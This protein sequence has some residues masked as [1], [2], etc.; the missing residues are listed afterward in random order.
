MNT[1][2]LVTG[3]ACSAFG[4]FA[5]FNKEFMWTLTEWSNALKGVKSER[6]EAWEQMNG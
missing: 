1:G 2:L 4:F 3:L 6:T 5:L